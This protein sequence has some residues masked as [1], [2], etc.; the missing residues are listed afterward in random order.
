[1]IS[2]CHVRIQKKAAICNPGRGVSPDT[3]ILDLPVSRSVI[4]GKVEPM[5][6]VPVSPWSD[7]EADKRTAAPRVGYALEQREK[8]GRS[9]RTARACVPEK[10]MLELPKGTRSYP[11]SALKRTACHCLFELPSSF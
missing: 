7:G 6:P 1:M 9:E 2:L 3:L 11:E 5:V 4:S 10:L 8:H